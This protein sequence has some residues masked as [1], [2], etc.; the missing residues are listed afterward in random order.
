MSVSGAWPDNRAILDL[1]NRFEAIAA[2]GFDGE[3]YEDALGA[4]VRRVRTQPGLAP[5]VAHVLGIMIDLIGE[6]DP[7]GRFAVKTAILREA[8]GRLRAGEGVP[9]GF[10]D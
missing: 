8:V 2:Q 1:A 6:S 4:L 3:P 10:Q 7:A 9:S 5:A